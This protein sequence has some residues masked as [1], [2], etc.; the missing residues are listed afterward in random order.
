L[1]YAKN[2]QLGG[3]KIT[4]TVSLSTPLVMTSPE[5]NFTLTSVAQIAISGY[6]NISLSD[7]TPVAF[8]R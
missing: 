4:I 8:E 7:N 2:R 5:W 6:N 3:K 1:G